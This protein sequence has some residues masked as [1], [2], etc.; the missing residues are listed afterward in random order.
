VAEGEEL[1]FDYGPDF[2]SEDDGVE[3]RHGQRVEVSLPAAP[4]SELAAASAAAG[5]RP[6]AASASGRTSVDS[7]TRDAAPPVLRDPRPPA[8]DCPSPASPTVPAAA[9]ATPNAAAAPT[10]TPVTTE[11]DTGKAEWKRLLAEAQQRTRDPAAPASPLPPPPPQPLQSARPPPSAAAV[12]VAAAPVAAPPVATPPAKA[13]PAR[14]GQAPA[15]DPNVPTAEEELLSGEE[16]QAAIYA[17]LMVE[18]E[19]DCDGGDGV[20]CEELSKEEEAKAAWIASANAAAGQAQRAAPPSAPAAAA[21]S[22]PPGTPARDPNLPTAEEEL[23]SG[24]ERQAAIYARLMAEMD[25]Q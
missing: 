14:S 23:L 24:E 6:A 4:W 9:P 10:T 20:A 12:P 19:A 7:E 18:M 25:S 16:R 8:R 13:P 1:C 21:P 22:A 11:D 17:R 2:W 5:G 15:R 3:T